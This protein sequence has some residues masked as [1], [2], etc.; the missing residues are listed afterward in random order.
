[1]K[2]TIILIGFV[3]LILA[4]HVNAG[5]YMGSIQSFLPK[6]QI[7]Q[8]IVDKLDLS[9]FRNSFGPMREPG[10]RFFSDFGMKPDKI[11]K[12]LIVFDKS[13][14]YYSIE[15]IE[16][17]DDNRDGIE[18]LISGRPETPVSG[19]GDHARQ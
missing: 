6:D 8:F 19:L 10:M 7:E 9:T 4:S 18:D 17:G 13:H 2:N 1:M 5:D 12:N 11:T 16:R 14:W 15:V 3:V